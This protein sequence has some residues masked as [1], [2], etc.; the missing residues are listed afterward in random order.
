M[1]GIPYLHCGCEMS[2]NLHYIF[3]SYQYHIIF[4][5]GIMESALYSQTGMAPW[6]GGGGQG[7]Q[8]PP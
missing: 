2:I 6:G 8:K 3:A 7:G 4:Q 1:H 5:K